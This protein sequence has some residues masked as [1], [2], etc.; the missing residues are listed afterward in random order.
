MAE[1]NHLALLYLERYPQQAAAVLEASNA[2]PGE[3]VELLAA[4]LDDVAAAVLSALTLTAAAVCLGALSDEVACRYLGHMPRRDAAA[5]VRLLPA[6]RRSALLRQLSAP[7]RVQIELMLRQSVHHVG[8][9]MDT[10][11]QAVPQSS[12]VDALRR[13]LRGLERPVSELYLVDDSGRLAGVVHPA[14]LYSAT[15]SDAAS[16]ISHMPPATLHTVSSIAQALV[17]PA[18][19]DA[20]VLPVIDGREKLVG[21]IRHATLRAAT[22]RQ[23]DQNRG[24]AGSDY[25]ALSNNLYVGLAEVLTTSIAKSPHGGPHVDVGN[26]RAGENG[27]PGT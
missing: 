8:A 27:A 24:D 26:R 12:T 6:E 4:L 22:K 5:V 23:R 20:D 11:F 14:R 16:A 10:N 25:L 1:Q 9:W 19:S 18:W 7:T 3:I 17:A 21:T 15:G 2:P 13:R